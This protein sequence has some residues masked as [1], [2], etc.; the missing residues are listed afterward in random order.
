VVWTVTS[1]GQ[2]LGGLFEAGTE[3]TA[4]VT[5]TAASGYTLTGV[6]AD[7]FNHTGKSGIS[8]GANSGVV[9]VT[10][11]ATTGVAAIPVDDLDLIYKVPV[12]V[13]GGTPA[14]YISSP[15]Y[16]GTVD[17]LVGG[18]DAPHSVFQSNM[19]YTAKVTL[20][21]AAGYSFGNPVVNMN[22]A[23]A[24]SGVASA[25]N[26]NGT[27]TVTV[28]FPATTAV[29]AVTVSDLDLTY[30]VPAPVNGGT[31]VAYV[32]APQY[33]GSVAWKRTDN[34]AGLSGLFGA[35]TAYTATV[36]LTAVSGYTFAGVGAG[37]DQ[38]R[39]FGSGNHHLSGDRQR[40]GGRGE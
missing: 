31:P 7:G 37:G 29:A 24:A 35:N 15:Q 8:N 19:A 32:S 17:W 40:G 3:Y 18:T 25:D 10:F 28:P 11:P 13:R 27:I 20:T 33:T 5:L 9:T 38:Q 21:A 4:V 16:T 34:N 23:G 26:G 12:P 2:A 6:G 14:A 30:R 22:H 39:G 1:G 36:T